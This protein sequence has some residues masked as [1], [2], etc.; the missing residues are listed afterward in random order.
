D[1]A[2]QL[3][4]TAE[5]ARVRI[6]R[7][8]PPRPRLHAPARPAGPE[9]AR[10]RFEAQL[11]LRQAGVGSRV[12]AEPS[13]SSSFSPP[14][15]L[16]E[17]ADVVTPPPTPPSAV[18]L[19]STPRL[20]DGLVDTLRRELDARAAA[21][22]SLRARVVTAETRLAARV[23]LDQ[24]MTATLE[25]LRKELYGLRGALQRERTLREAAERRVAQLEG[26]LGGQRERSRDAYAAIGELRGALDYLRPASPP[27]PPEPL[28]PAAPAQGADDSGSAPGGAG[29]V[30]A[31]RLT[32]AFTRL[33][34]S[35]APPEPVGDP[36][37]GSLVLAGVG[38]PTLAAAFRRL[39][40]SDA[41]AAGQ[42]LLELLALQRVVY[43]HPIAYD[44][45]LGPGRG[46]VRV[47]VGESEARV[48][49]HGGARS[50]EEVAFRVTGAPDRIARLLIA[51]GLWRR[52]GGRVAGWLGLRFPRVRGRR[53]GLAALHALLAL[54]L[55]LVALRDA[56]VTLAPTTAL[57]LIAA[58]VKPAWTAG[59]RFTLAY[60]D[61]E[62]DSA[63]RV[64]LVVRDGRP[65]EVTRSAPEG[66]IAITITGPGEALLAVLAGS[67]APAAAIDGDAGPLDTL[68]GWI[69]RAQ[70][71]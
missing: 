62:R 3:A 10:L 1:E 24:R 21:D 66:R 67:P 35:V 5:A 29:P 61:A 18:S 60:Q 25:Q 8:V 15:R 44:L 47:S 26:E 43:P 16:P 48:E 50:R 31:A 28:P 56:G 34:E 9:S 37:T 2:E 64:Y 36:L 42:L 23:L 58:M 57:H 33:R 52:L 45:V 7:Q 4:A 30:Q 59:E 11:R 53:D 41:G 17:P 54:P 46:C 63:G 39:V 32:D 68:R 12:P 19:P 69:K 71:E 14:P 38:R 40:R 20:S 22:A 65:I 27:P 51:R 70:S 55:D 13:P 6:E 49:L